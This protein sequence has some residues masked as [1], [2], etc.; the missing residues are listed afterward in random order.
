MHY[1]LLVMQYKLNQ[2]GPEM[3]LHRE[4]FLIYNKK[5]RTQMLIL[6]H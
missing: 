6:G 1:L 3:L 4:D 5:V 2:Q